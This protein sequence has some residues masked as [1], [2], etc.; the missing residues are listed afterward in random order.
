MNENLTSK[1][2]KHSEAYERIRLALLW[3]KNNNHLY[4][5][6]LARFE[7]LYWYVRHDIINPEI[8]KID[9]GK[10]LECEAL[11]LAFPIDSDYFKQYSPLYGKMDLASV[12]NPKPHVIESVQN[13]IHE[14]RKQQAFNMGKNIC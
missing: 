13:N 3:L 11:G 8:L 9:Q 4:K 7:T 10:I 12:Q 5:S 6:F 1:L 2:T 14:L